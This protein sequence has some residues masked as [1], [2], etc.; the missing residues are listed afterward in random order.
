MQVTIAHRVSARGLG[1]H[2][3]KS[4]RATFSP[5]PV[6]TGVVFRRVDCSPIVEIP[7]HI[8]FISGTCM[9]TTLER[10][11]VKVATVEHL[12]SAVAGTGIDNLYVDLDCPEVPIMD[13]SSAPFV[14]LLKCAGL[15]YQTEKRCVIRVTEPV[16]VRNGRGAYCRLLPY[17]GRKLDFSVDFDHP[18]FSDKTQIAS[19]DLEKECYFIDVS[20]ARTFGFVSQLE[21]LRKQNLVLG[22]SLDNAV[23]LDSCRV[24]NPDGLRYGNEFAMHKIL[25]AIGDLHLSG[26]LIQGHFVGYCSGHG[27]N[28]LLLDKL[29]ASRAFEVV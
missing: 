27:M 13:G 26:N 11:G 7:A 6:N 23:G 24:L 21:Q 10:N 2:S 19:I 25:D 15:C 5:A 3:G 18:V 4:V 9:C 20:R 14:F 16:E 17:Q 1:L 12:L 28:K 22:A 29:M 8:S